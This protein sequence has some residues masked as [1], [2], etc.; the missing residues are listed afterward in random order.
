MGRAWRLSILLMALL[1]GCVGEPSPTASSPRSLVDVQ[2]W[3]Y[4]LQSIDPQKLAVLDVDLI[5]MDYAD[6]DGVPFSREEIDQ[7]RAGNK[8][9]LSY[10]SIGEAEA[11]RPYWKAS[12]GGGDCPAPLSPSAPDW[13]DPVNSEWCGNYPV[14][15]W[16]A[17]WSIPSI[18][19]SARKTWG[20]PSRTP[21]LPSRWSTW[22]G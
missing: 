14:Q 17:E 10:L 21:M 1:T 5:V 7:I 18:T 20:N 6:N 2:S 4:Q 19:G 16:R 3:A 11:Y 13:L 8:I 15:F 22:S 9:V 12:W